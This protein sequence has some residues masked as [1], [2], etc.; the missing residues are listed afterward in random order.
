MYF[1]G[2]LAITGLGNRAYL[3][4]GDHAAVVIDPPR[5][6]ERV[7]L[8]AA[9]RGVRITH[10][11]ETHIHNDYVTGGLELARVTGAQYLVPVDARVSFAR[12]PVAHGDF[13]ELEPGLGVRA[14]TTP[15]H[16]PHHTSYVLDEADRPVA[17]FTGGRC[18]SARSAALTWSI[19]V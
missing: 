16:T 4:G 5:D 7:I 8:A 19:L 11:A 14:I 10:V 6:I 18:S 2:T 17:A 3:A 12:V 1:V 13:F 9:R 15:G